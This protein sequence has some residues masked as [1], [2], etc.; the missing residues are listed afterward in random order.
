MLAELRPSRATPPYNI[1]P[2]VHTGAPK[3]SGWFSPNYERSL[4]KS[5]RI[6][7]SEISK[8]FEISLRFAKISLRKI[9]ASNRERREA[10]ACGGSL[11]GWLTDAFCSLKLGPEIFRTLAAQRAAIG[12][13]W[14]PFGQ[15]AARAAMPLASS[16]AH[17][18]KKD[19][20]HS[21]AG[22]CEA[23]SSSHAA[24]NT[25]SATLAP[26]RKQAGGVIL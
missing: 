16:V 24:S 6:L 9:L 18:L 7:R 19:G 13:R 23:K 20:R 1:E 15:P 17:I 8:D 12:N 4:V 2:S 11:R 5:I 26:S 10:R 14:L 25:P 22:F 21:S 3:G